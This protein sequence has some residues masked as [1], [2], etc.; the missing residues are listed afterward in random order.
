MSLLSRATG[1]TRAR[2]KNDFYATI[3]ARAAAALAPFLPPGTVYGEPC[4]GAGD[5][6]QLLEAHGLVCDWGLELEPQGPCLRNR[7]PI[8]IGDALQLGRADLGA[9]QV[10]ISNPPWYRPSLH[11][12]IEHLARLLPC[13]FLFDAAWMQNQAAAPIGTLCTD[14]VAVGR[15][16]WIEDSEH[17]STTDVA[18]YRFDA[19]KDPAEP[20]R[21]HWRGSSAAAQLRLAW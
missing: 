7:W 16:T 2:R 12:L 10:L 11:A 8:G 4:A 15:L 1:T 13:W 18:W 6:V 9:A 5:L 20:T 3:D 19:G 17:D 14:I 21:Y